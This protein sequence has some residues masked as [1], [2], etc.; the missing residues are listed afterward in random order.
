M[1]SAGTLVTVGRDEDLPSD[2]GI[3]V[4]THQEVL[5]SHRNARLTPFARRRIVERVRSGQPVA[6]VAKAMGVSRQCAHRWV[7]RFDEHGDD[8]LEDR[9]SRPHR[10][11]N[12]TAPEIEEKVLAARRELRCG[13]DQ[14]THEVGCRRG[15]SLAPCA[16]T[17]YLDCMTVTR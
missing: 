7:N 12:Q 3:A 13:P 5:M 8:G 11:P 17:E 14:L 2:V 9:S 10:C 1:Y 6:H 4:S 15:R 16:A